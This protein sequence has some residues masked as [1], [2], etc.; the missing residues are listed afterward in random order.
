MIL[1]LSC[2]AQCLG[3]RCWLSHR[4]TLPAAPFPQIAEQLLCIRPVLHCPVMQLLVQLHSPAWLP[5]NTSGIP[6]CVS[7]CL[8][9]SIG[10]PLRSAVFLYMVIVS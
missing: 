5:V 8:S 9:L 7:A 6:S 1:G 4:S 3:R 2:S 10:K